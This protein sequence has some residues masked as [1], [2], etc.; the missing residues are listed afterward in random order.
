MIDITAITKLADIE[1]RTIC[2]VG[3][4]S[5]AKCSIAG[6]IPAAERTILV[7]P[8]P[9]LA[10]ELENAFPT[11][12]V[13]QCA[14]GDKVAIGKLY[15]RGEGSWI[16]QVP[17]GCAPDEHVR[18]SHMVRE[19]FEARFVR[20]IQINTMD[21]IDDGKIDVLCVDVEGAEWFIIKHM[22]SRP[23]LIRL[24]THFSHSEY[25]NPHIK[26]IDMWMAENGYCA[27]IQDVSDT[28]WLHQSV[29]P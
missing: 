1:P 15:D 18:H 7:E 29:M 3:V 4:N 5:P 9:W 6:L 24:E 27:I 20:P 19:K 8:L 10:L 16:D 21:S 14:I 26:E 12:N 17:E 13:Y 28:L 2:E 23:K 25:V 22:K 11:A